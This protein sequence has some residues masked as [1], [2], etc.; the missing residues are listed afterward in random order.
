M[1]VQSHPPLHLTYCLNVHPGET[2]D[3]NFAAVRDQAL[4]IKR[5]VGRP[6]P[7]GLGLR[8]SWAAAQTLAVPARLD[9]FRAFCRT[10]D[11]YVFT[12]NGFPYGRFHG[13]PVKT[14]V[15]RPDWRQRERLDYTKLL[16]DLLAALLPD[17]VRGTISTV[18]GSYKPWITTGADLQALVVN[19]ADAAAHAADTLASTG[20]SIALALEPEPDCLIENTRETIHFFTGPL[21]EW[22]IAHLRVQRGMSAEA[23]EATLARH[24][25]VCFDTVHMAVA[26]EDLADSLDRLRAAGVPVSKI[27]LGAALGVRDGADAPAALLNFCE[28][29]YLHQTRRQSPD[30]SEHAFADLPEALAAPAPPDACWRVHF[31][32]PLFFEGS[33]DLRST[34]S[35]LTPRFA[36]L[37]AAGATEQVE[38]E[39]YTYGV[40]PPDLATGDLAES[41]A[42][43]Y[44]WALSHLLGGR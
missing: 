29:V 5:L 40:L 2:W 25:G 38:I 10:N 9:A 6:G 35:L 14:N 27:H 18:P 44:R 23:A 28:D 16:T 30:G 15:Y 21:R 17:G 3:E 32:V 11:L 4:R 12:I 41:I 19:I 1:R 31:H 33:G 34:Q 42:R 8:L 22:G 7:F 13:G 43:E 36:Q 24:V 37:V 26:F 20:K 39:T